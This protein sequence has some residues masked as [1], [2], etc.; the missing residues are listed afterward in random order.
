MATSTPS[1]SWIQHKISFFFSHLPC[2][3][4]S[5]CWDCLLV[6]SLVTNS[7]VSSQSYS[8]DVAAKAFE[9]GQW[10]SR[11]WNLSSLCFWDTTAYFHFLLLVPFCCPNFWK[12]RQFS[13]PLCWDLFCIYTWSSV[14]SSQPLA[15]II[16]Y[17]KLRMLSLT[18]ISLL[19]FSWLGSIFS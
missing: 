16:M 10:V 9:S 18:W 17:F 13:R 8:L 7:L 11:L 19:T 2:Y 3:L 15:G 5:S 14:I 12:I 4:N 6:T 1:L